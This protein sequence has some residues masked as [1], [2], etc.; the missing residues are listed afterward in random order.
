MS[1]L[2]RRGFLA[3]LASLCIP[4]SKLLGQ[5][6]R[7]DTAQL[8]IRNIS[9][10]SDVKPIGPILPPLGLVDSEAAASDLLAMIKLLVSEKMY[11]DFF[12]TASDRKG[13]DKYNYVRDA[14]SGL[15]TTLVAKAK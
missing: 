5:L 10:K 11:D 7:P 2:R 12:R 15:L 4:G 6:V 14:L 13:I 3:V 9:P 8:S 1:A